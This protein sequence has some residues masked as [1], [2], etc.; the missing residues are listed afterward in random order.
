MSE[1]KQWGIWPY[2]CLCAAFAGYLV[3]SY[4]WSEKLIAFQRE[5]EKLGHG[6]RYRPCESCPQTGFKW[7]T[8]PAKETAT[9][10]TQN[11]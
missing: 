1:R 9:L 10:N 6:E 8:A 11:R 2:L 5:A 4:V 7:V 3:G